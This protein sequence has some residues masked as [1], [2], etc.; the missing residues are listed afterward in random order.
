MPGI[1]SRQPAALLLRFVARRAQ[2]V[3]FESN[4]LLLLCTCTRQMTLQRGSVLEAVAGQVL[5]SSFPCPL[6]AVWRSAQQHGCAAAIRHRAGACGVPFI[7]KQSV[8]QSCCS[9]ALRVYPRCSVGT[10]CTHGLRIVPM[11][12]C[13]GR[14]HCVQECGSTVC[15]ASVLHWVLLFL[16]QH[17]VS[18][19]FLVVKLHCSMKP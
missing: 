16:Q 8:S 2:A 18:S 7:C 5:L 1:K 15:C 10:T 3:R 14:L 11:T 19:P 17:D 12:D 13:I 6:H 9:C 4:V